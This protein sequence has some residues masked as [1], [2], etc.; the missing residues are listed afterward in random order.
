MHG[1]S[2]RSLIQTAGRA[3]RNAEGR[4]ILYGDNMTG[5]MGA[6]IRETNRRREK[7]MAYNK[8]HGITPETVK[9]NIGDILSDVA[10]GDHVT[11]DL[12]DEKIE[13]RIG[14][15]L[16]AHLEELKKRMLEAASNLEFEEAAR[17]RDEMKRL[18]GAELGL[19]DPMA[20][21]I[22]RPTGRSNAGKGGTRA[23]KGK[24]RRKMY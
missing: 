18:E 1:R 17:L 7:Q 15:N 19:Q 11:I 8:E 12:G 6:A 24:S 4:V 3:A 14:H 16:E 9:K 20:K 21:N 22:G 2:D 13:H 5:S 23:Y 10:S